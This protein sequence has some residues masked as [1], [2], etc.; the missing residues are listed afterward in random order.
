MKHRNWSDGVRN[1]DSGG[2]KKVAE[3]VSSLEHLIKKNIYISQNVNKMQRKQYIMYLFHDS[4]LHLYLA[5]RE[6]MHVVLVIRLETG[7][8]LVLGV[9]AKARA[10][11]AWRARW[12]STRVKRSLCTVCRCSYCNIFHTTCLGC[13]H[14]YCNLF[15]AT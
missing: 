2:E 9:S 4:K 12:Y 11:G 6:A 8:L 15:H 7:C 3:G 1:T 5:S 10:G 14:S 13:R